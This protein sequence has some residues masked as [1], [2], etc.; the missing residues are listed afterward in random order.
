MCFNDCIKHF[1]RVTRVGRRTRG[2]GGGSQRGMGRLE[3]GD[4]HRAEGAGRLAQGDWRKAAGVRWRVQG[5]RH[6]M[7]SAGGWCGVIG[8]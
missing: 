7:A 3:R 1:V 4:R 8:T 2:G 5:D 6:M